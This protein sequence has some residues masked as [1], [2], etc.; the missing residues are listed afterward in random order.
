MTALFSLQRPLREMG[1]R[2]MEEDGEWE[3]IK[4]GGANGGEMKERK[5]WQRK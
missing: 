4:D 2:W 5:G 1:L 3:E